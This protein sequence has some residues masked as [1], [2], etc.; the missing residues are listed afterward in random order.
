MFL[1]FLT[2]TL[3]FSLVYF[4]L[5][6]L[7]QCAVRAVFLVSENPPRR[8]RLTVAMIVLLVQT[9]RFPMKQVNVTG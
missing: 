4:I 6:F 3:L 7:A 8:E 1:V 2:Y 9:M 5:S